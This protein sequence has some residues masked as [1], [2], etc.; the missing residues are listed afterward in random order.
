MKSARDRMDII[1]AYREVGT[2]RGAAQITGTTPKTVKRV[3]DRHEA[4]GGAPE[5]T[6]RRRNYDGVAELVAPRVQKTAGRIS[7][8]RLLPAA[9]AAG[10]GGSSRNFRRLV[11]AQKQLWRR[12]NHHGRRPAVWSPGEHLV[13]DWG[14]LGGLHVFCAVLAWCRVR[15]VR[16]ATD[17]RAETTLAMLAECFEVLG[18]V[19]GVVLADRMGC[20]KGGVVANRVVPTPQYLRLAA[21]YGFR[22]DFCE[23]N[24]PQSKGIV[25]NLV[26]Y[27]KR[28]LIVPQ[29]P[30][31][32]L[33]AANEQARAWCVEVNAAL[34]S[35]I[36][37]V[38]AEQLVIERELLAPLPS[39]R[40]SIGRAVTRK[41]DRLSCVRFGSARYSVPTRFIGEQVGLRTDDGRL[42]V[43]V[44]GTGQVVAEHTL[45]AP[46]EASV[47]D[48]HYG[49]PRPAPQRAVRPKTVAEKEFCALGP[50]AEAFITGAAAAGNTRLGAELA[51]LNTLRAAHGDEAFLA[52]LGRAVAFGR[53]HAADLRSILAAGA[54]TADPRS[55]GDV[56]VLELPVVP[57]RSLADYAIGEQS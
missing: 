7:A 18:G 26:G 24:D 22:P 5:R 42:L 27:A 15:F 39:L 50:V 52:A 48:A 19:P 20:V 56:L 16:F 30:F 53:W 34:H 51:Q 49:G 9:R 28:D 3:I 4:G 40:P 38:P 1:S 29:A 36:C 43:V 10:Y 21:H 46:G 25:E 37:A 55:A 2:Y 23:A 44:S 33:A 54:G 11:A 47:L 13:I 32:D 41:V 57:V 31:T 12:D 14:V 6:P 17:E 45:V 8:K 35:E